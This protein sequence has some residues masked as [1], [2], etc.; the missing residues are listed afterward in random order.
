MPR[1]RHHTDD[2]GLMGIRAKNAIDPARGVGH[3][4]AGVHVE[5]EPFGSPLPGR[6]GPKSQMGCDA[7]SAYVEF[8]APPEMVRT[9]IGVRNTAMIARRINEPLSL[10][11]LNPRFVKVRRHWWEFWRSTK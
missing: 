5:L 2:H 8:V 10:G 11:G 1:V 6:E 7:E 4:E 3:I 9:N